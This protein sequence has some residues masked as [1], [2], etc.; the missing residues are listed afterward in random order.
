MKAKS[1]I[2]LSVGALLI[3]G[4]AF[5]QQISAGRG[6]LMTTVPA[7]SRTVTNW[8][9][10]SVY[11]TSD[12]KIGSVDDVLVDP[13][14]QISAVIVGVGGTMSADKDVAVNFSAIKPTTKN[15]KTY[16]T[17]DASQDALKGAPGLK[18]DRTKTTWVPDNSS[19]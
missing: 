18:Y 8:Y 12:N 10:Q 6:D 15:D 13:N 14:G 7:S 2:V 16:L 17:M 1:F 5:A 19:K 4:G 9:K 3:S 11:D